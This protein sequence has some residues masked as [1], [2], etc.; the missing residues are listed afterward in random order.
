MENTASQFDLLGQLRSL[1]VQR[2]E[3]AEAFDVFKQDAVLAPAPDI[4]NNE[5]SS[6]E[7]ADVAAE[8]VDTF[9]AQ[10]EGLLASATDDELWP[11]T[12]R[13][14]A[15]WA[16][17]RLR[18]YVMSC[19]VGISKSEPTKCQSGIFI[20]VADR[21][22]QIGRCGKR[23]PLSRQRLARMSPSASQNGSSTFFVIPPIHRT[24][25]VSRPRL[26]SSLE[27]P[28]NSFG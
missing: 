20:C 9:K 18:R 13:P 10:T 24:G 5:V 19:G 8:E 25:V 28:G 22:C 23:R 15:R 14:K 11:R 4:P 17:L 3:A 26:T 21:V 27:R 12:G 1:I 16:I 2:N 7:A 6:D